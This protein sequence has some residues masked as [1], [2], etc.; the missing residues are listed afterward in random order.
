MEPC[1]TPDSIEIRDEI[2][3]TPETT[4]L[5]IILNY[6]NSTDYTFNIMQYNQQNLY[7]LFI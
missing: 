6:V 1:G 5:Q 3:S 2:L 4:I 7:F